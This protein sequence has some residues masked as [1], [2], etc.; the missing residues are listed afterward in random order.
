MEAGVPQGSILAPTLYSASTSDMPTR[1]DT[2][3]ATFADDVAILA[4]AENPE[5]AATGLQNHLNELQGWM[6]KWRIKV[7]TEKSQHITFTLRRKQCP[8]LF[9]NNDRI[10]TKSSVRYLG[11]LIDNRLTWQEHIKTK[12][13]T[14]NNRLKTLYRLL[15]HKSAPSLKQKLLIYTSLLRPIW[16]YGAQIFGTAKNSNIRRIQAFQS[17]FLRLITGA[18]LYVNSNTTFGPQ[19]TIRIRSHQVELRTI[20]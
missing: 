11:L 18:P 6:N 20:S 1:N 13:L 4:Q 16:S 12:R 8:P 2:I 3:T 14:L 5:E 17:K 10:P 15:H 7:N 19:Y 9:L